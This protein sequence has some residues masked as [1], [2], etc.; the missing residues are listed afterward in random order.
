MMATHDELISV[1]SFFLILTTFV[2]G[3]RILVRLKLGGKGAF[4][5]DDVFLVVS[6]VRLTLPDY[7]HDSRASSLPG[8]LA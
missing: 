2:V 7:G 1:A 5:W 8:L 6:Y 4:G 3:L